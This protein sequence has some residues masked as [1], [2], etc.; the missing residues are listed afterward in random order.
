MNTTPWNKGKPYWKIRGSRNPNW[1]GGIT[2]LDQTERSRIEFVQWRKKVFSKNKPICVVCGSKMYL[3]AH[4]KKSFKEF[5]LLRYEVENGIIVCRR[6]QPGIH[7]Y[8]L[9][10]MKKLGA[11]LFIKKCITCRNKFNVP[12]YRRE[13]ASYCSHKCHYNRPDRLSH[14]EKLQ[15]KRN[16]YLKNKK[17]ILLKRHA[18]PNN[19]SR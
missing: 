11:S 10:Y 6:C 9:K 17:I 12:T 16:W 3:I 8:G 5:S 4:H 2:S 18:V 1:K 19:N 7:R 13:S 15:Y 14:A